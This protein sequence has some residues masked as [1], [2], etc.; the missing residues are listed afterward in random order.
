MGAVQHNICYYVDLMLPS[1]SSELV[2]SVFEVNVII[3]AKTY[4]FLIS[5]IKLEM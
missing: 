2:L 1:M 5:D 3:I 4:S